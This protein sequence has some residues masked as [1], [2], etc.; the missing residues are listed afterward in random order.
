MPVERHAG[1][2]EAGRH[3]ENKRQG[4]VR[5]AHMEEDGGLREEEKNEGNL[6][7]TEME[8]KKFRSGEV[9][10]YGERREMRANS[11]AEKVDGGYN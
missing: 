10:G 1:C 5:L 9:A 3:G 2:S 6:V 4:G 7:E 11:K 8:V